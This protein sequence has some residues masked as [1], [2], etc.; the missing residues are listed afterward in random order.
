MAKFH[1]EILSAS[2]VKKLKLASHA[3]FDAGT[4]LSRRPRAAF[5]RSLGFP[6]LVRARKVSARNRKVRKLARLFAEA[7]R[8]TVRARYAT[9]R[10]LIPTVIQLLQAR[11]RDLRGR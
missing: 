9:A 7:K 2:S 8:R 10:V 3:F 4:S 1:A 11:A 5:W 6:N